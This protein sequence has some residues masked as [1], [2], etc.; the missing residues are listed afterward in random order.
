MESQKDRHKTVRCKV[1]S[2]PIRSDHVKRHMGT[3]KDIMTMTDEE[4]RDELRARHTTQIHREER[5]QEIEEIAQREGVPINLCDD[6]KSNKL[7]TK[8]LRDELLHNNQDY[9]DKIEL[10]KQIAAII[11]E[12]VVREESLKREYKEALDLYRKQMPRIDMQLALLRP[13]QAELMKMISKSCSHREVFWIC[14]FNGNE[15][16]SWFQG[17]LETFY[18][19]ARVVRLDLRNKTGNILHTLSKRPLQT[20]DIFLFNDTRAADHN[21]QNYEVLEHIKDGSAVSSKYNSSVLTFK[22]PNLLIVFSNNQPN[23]AE[24]S[25]DR[26]RIYSINK[27]GLRCLNKGRKISL[28][29]EE[30]RAE[31]GQEWYERKTILH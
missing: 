29:E 10:G 14:G 16:K 24:L 8:S 4:A 27:E 6:A 26:W 19:Y 18:G 21:W 9:L 13:W 23:T 15:G 20:T 31:H 7:D 5:R 3:H 25:R 28:N 2:K 12:G 17:Y 1:C 30:G 11:D 22:T